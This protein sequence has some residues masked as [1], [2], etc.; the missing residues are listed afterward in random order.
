LQLKTNWPT[1]ASSVLITHPILWTTTCSHDWKNNLKIAIF[2]P[3]RR[4]SLPRGPCWTKKVLIFFEWYS[5]VRVT[6]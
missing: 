2:R 5:E 3:T 4:S 6:G 1:W